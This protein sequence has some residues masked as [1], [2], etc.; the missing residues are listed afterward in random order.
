MKTKLALD[1]G[2]ASIG[3]TAFNVDKNGNYVN[4]LETESLIWKES[5]DRMGT[6]LSKKRR[7]ARLAR[8]LIKRQDNRS[9]KIVNLHHLFNISKDDLNKVDSNRL[10][11][12]R[13]KALDEK[14][15][16]TELL[17]ILLRLSK[18]RGFNFEVKDSG[19]TGKR[20]SVAL[21]LLDGYR[22]LGSD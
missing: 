8:R 1:I 17:R 10:V 5:I 22:T 12:L 13:A 16:L 2:T 14:V 3:Y 21:S 11:E 19:E 15:E 4:I 6:L 7:S 20:Q 9:C 18:N